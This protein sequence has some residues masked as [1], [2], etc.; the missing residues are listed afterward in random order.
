MAN[1]E[2]LYKQ[3]IEETQEKINL[4]A[5]NNNKPGEITQIE[6][7]NAVKMLY[8]AHL[9]AE[10]KAVKKVSTKKTTKAVKKD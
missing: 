2:Q 4:F 10:K 9:E 3:L 7:L 6:V 1:I 8:A 5:I